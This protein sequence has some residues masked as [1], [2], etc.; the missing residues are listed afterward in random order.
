[1]GDMLV[2]VGSVQA[3]PTHMHACSSHACTPTLSSST[4][5]HLLCMC[6]CVVFICG[7]V[8]LHK[9]DPYKHSPK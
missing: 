3:T 4:R 1:M 9:I 8:C 5:P 7:W 6:V 2:S